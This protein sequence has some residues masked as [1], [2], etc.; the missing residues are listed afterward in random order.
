M[1]SKKAL[2]LAVVLCLLLPLS[3][4]R[5]RTNGS[6]QSGAE[7]INEELSGSLPSDRAEEQEAAENSEPG[8][9]TK[10]NPES[11]RK[12]YDET[13]AAE[14]V[15]GTPRQLHGE[16][17]G[18][19]TP[20]LRED[21]PESV[22]RLND[23]AGET[24]TQTVAAEQA[25][26]MGVSEDAEAADSAMTYF[27]VLLRDRT[28]SLFECQR[29]YV[30]WETAEDHVTVHKSSPEHALILSAGAYDV[31]ARLL[32]ENLRVDDGWVARKNPGVIVKVVDGGVLG[33]GVSSLGAAKAEY[34]ALIS[35]PG[36]NAIDAVRAGR[37]ALLS[38]ELLKTPWL[39]TAAMLVIAK[40]ANEALLSDVDLNEALRMLTEEATGS[41]PTG[42]YFYNGKEE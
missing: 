15:P 11:S 40:T 1:K 34:Q 31:S 28:G 9:R 25:E 30:Y 21:A 17:A 23:H 8:N 3:G 24:A 10:E 5:T 4:C 19:G 12:E 42:I 36:W 6:N 32:P 14:I 33:S 29:A 16:G 22:S 27:T 35:R 13:A 7:S 18:G 41:L 26:E 2:L 38:E 37:V 20:V 39:Q